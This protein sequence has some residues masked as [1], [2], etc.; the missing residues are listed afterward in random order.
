MKMQK[1][2]IVFFV[3]SAVVMSSCVKE[4]ISGASTPVK[5][6]V[7]ALVAA[8]GATVGAIKFKK[9]T[10][11]PHTHRESFCEVPPMDDAPKSS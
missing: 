11:I 6:T 4:V 1:V 2:A 5:L 7:K 9:N 8:V 3:V 10:H